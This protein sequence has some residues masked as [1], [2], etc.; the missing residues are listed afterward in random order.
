MADRKQLEDALIAAHEAGDTEAAE[1]FAQEIKALTPPRQRTWGEQIKRDAGLTGRALINGVA[2]IPLM[3]MDAGVAARNLLTGSNYD[4]ASKMWNDGMNELGFPEPEGWREKGSMLIGE[5]AAGGKLPL[6]TAKG[7]AEVP[8]TFTARDT[9]RAVTQR[10]AADAGLV[11]PPSTT[12]PTIF[13]KLLESL[14]GK[15]ATQQQA[16]L[17]NQT[18]AN[19]LVNKALGRPEGAELTKD[20][21]ATIRGN[22]VN[23]AYKPVRG[24]G[25]I[26][27]DSKFSQTIDDVTAKT[28]KVAKQFPELGDQKLTETIQALKKGSVDSDVAVDTISVLRDKASEAFAQGKNEAGRAYRAVSKAFE[29]AIERALERRG[30]DASDVLKAYRDG[31]QLIAKTHSRYKGAFAAAQ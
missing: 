28:D 3:A 23:Q 9:V 14:G 15:V 31:R 30:K 8:K 21:M 12:N 26:R 24:I 13:N 20:A 7:A 29:D 17:I 22:V 16:S 5:M 6:P 11:V 18:R 2:G 27:L 10:E 19:S 4:S 25:T 1:L